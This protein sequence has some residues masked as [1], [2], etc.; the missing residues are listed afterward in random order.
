MAHFLGSFGRAGGSLRGFQTAA[1]N[2]NIMR[3]IVA[4]T[5][6]HREV[7]TFTYEMSAKEMVDAGGYAHVDIAI[8]AENYKFGPPMQSS[9]IFDFEERVL[10][11]DVE[12]VQGFGPF[13]ET[14]KRFGVRRFATLAETLLL[15]AT[16]TSRQREFPIVCVTKE[17][18]FYAEDEDDLFPALTVAGESR[19]VTLARW[20]SES[21]TIEL[22]GRPWN[23]PWGVA[24]TTPRINEI[25]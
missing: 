4:L 5:D 24:V 12:I 20:D 23:G 15:G 3:Q 13:V 14:M 9:G 2:Q 25:G 11:P 18:F 10:L 7:P 6:P 22:W 16:E 1:D 19:V 21:S 17:S 8:N